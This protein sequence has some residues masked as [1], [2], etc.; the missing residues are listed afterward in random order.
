MIVVTTVLR[1]ESEPLIS[2]VDGLQQQLE[3]IA[4][5]E[6]FSAKDSLLGLLRFLVEHSIRDADGPV[7]ETEI[8]VRHFREATLRRAHRLDRAS[9]DR[10]SA[11]CPG[12][13]LLR[14]R[15]GR[16]HHPRSAQG[17]VSGPVLLALKASVWKRGGIRRALRSPGLVETG[18]IAPSRK[19]SVSRTPLD[20]HRGGSCLP[21]AVVRYRA[22]HCRSGPSAIETFWRPLVQ[23]SE[24]ALVIFSNPRFVGQSITGLRLYDPTRTNSAVDQRDLLRHGRSFRR[25]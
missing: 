21:G 23:H 3:R 1:D 19:S 5:S 22:E 20:W 13:V 6:V 24:D 12:S 11:G 14:P 9:P 18:I 10:P 25:A 16:P 4:N 2:D 7:R 8:G 17:W 15:C